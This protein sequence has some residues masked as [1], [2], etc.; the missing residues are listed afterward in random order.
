MRTQKTYMAI[1]PVR[2][3]NSRCRPNSEATLAVWMM[4]LLGRQAM[5]G[6]DPPMS[7][8]STTAVL[9]PSLAI[10]QARD[11]PPAPLPSTRTSYLS[12][13]LMH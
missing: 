13:S 12:A 6:Q 3:P 7:F 8:R 11:L 1:G 2:I 9:L 4:F 5:F 10:A